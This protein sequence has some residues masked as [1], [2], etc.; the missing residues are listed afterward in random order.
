MRGDFQGLGLHHATPMRSLRLSDG[1]P[2]ETVGPTEGDAGMSRITVY[3]K[4]DCVQCAATCR[5]L[6]GAGLE[7]TIVDLSTD[8]TAMS[9]VTVDLGYRQAPVVVVGDHDHWSGFRP[10]HIDRIAKAEQVRA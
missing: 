3:T 2:S 9:Y 1:M 8:A 6:D 7:Y 5:A 10:D 4:P